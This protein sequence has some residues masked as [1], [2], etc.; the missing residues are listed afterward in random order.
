MSLHVAYA[1]Q[2]Q[3]GKTS[4]AIWTSRGAWATERRRSVA[5]D[6]NPGTPWGPQCLVFGHGRLEEFWRFVW[7]RKNLNVYVDEVATS[8]PRDVDAIEA[9]TRIR[10]RGHV[11]HVLIH[12]ANLLLPIQRDQ[13]GTLFLFNQ[14]PGSA[15]MFAE[16]WNDE[17]I[18][19]CTSLPK[20]H[21]LLCRKFADKA[22]GMHSIVPGIFPRP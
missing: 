4:A 6:P 1:G 22:T 19:Q 5:Y 3:A 12:H 17:R 13:L 21:F 14:H 10:H 15:K 20:Y 18:Y 11:L 7:A 9:F 16:E 8:M 2:S